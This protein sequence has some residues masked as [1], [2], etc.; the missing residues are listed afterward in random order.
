MSRL[1]YIDVPVLA[2]INAGGLFFDLGPQIGFLMAARQK[3]G[4]AGNAGSVTSERHQKP[5]PHS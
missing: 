2:R 3:D 1:Y 4:I 5:G